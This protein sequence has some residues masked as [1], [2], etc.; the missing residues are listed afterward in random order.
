M[1]WPSNLDRNGQ[2]WPS[3]LFSSLRILNIRFRWLGHP[4]LRTKPPAEPLKS[5]HFGYQVGALFIHYIGIMSGCCSVMT[6]DGLETLRNYNCTDYH[7]S[8][9]APIPLLLKQ[10]YLNQ[11]D[12]HHMDSLP[13][14]SEYESKWEGTHCS[15]RHHQGTYPMYGKCLNQAQPEIDCEL[16]ICCSYIHGGVQQIEFEYGILSPFGSDLYSCRENWS[17]RKHHTWLGDQHFGT[18]WPTTGC[19]IYL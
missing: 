13:E 15:S 7:C 18:K 1:K 10:A 3:L 8:V 19:K 11:W 5:E 4:W 16:R 12:I 6:F 17:H 14:I 2:I 9:K